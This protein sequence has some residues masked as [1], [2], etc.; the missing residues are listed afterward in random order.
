MTEKQIFVDGFQ[1]SAFKKIE[2]GSKQVE[3]M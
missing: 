2:G 1:Y 3:L